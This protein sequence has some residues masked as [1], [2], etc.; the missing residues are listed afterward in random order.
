MLAGLLL[1][2]L[3]GCAN[4]DVIVQ[5]QGEMEKRLESLAKTGGL[6][7][8]QISDLSAEISRLQESRRQDR[9]DFEL[10]KGNLKAYRVEMAEREP[11]RAESISRIEVVNRE[12]GD[13][14]SGP[15]AD[16]VKAFGLFSANDYGSAIEAFEAFIRANPDSE[17]AGNARYWIGECHYARGEYEP[18]RAAYQAVI[19]SYPASS[20]I[21]DAML[22]AGYSLLNMNDQ[23]R[24]STVLNE[25][26]RLHPDNPA[27]ASA[28]ERIISINGSKR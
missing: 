12:T 23:V 25:L 17:Y 11:P 6:Q 5:K 4:M 15:P 14:E 28:R 20:K 10:I 26:I 22:K 1:I 18:A 7:A 2:A 21:P 19:D 9:A 24:G 3:P 16:Y 27:A 13:R 8:Q